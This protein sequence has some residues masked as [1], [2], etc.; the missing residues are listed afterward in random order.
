MIRQEIQSTLNLFKRVHKKQIAPKTPLLSP[1]ME[2]SIKRKN[3]KRMTDLELKRLLKTLIKEIDL[4]Q[5]NREK[6]HAGLLKFKDS[7]NSL[8]IN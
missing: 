6:P 3:L 8:I 4:Y 2:A 1:K 5:N 7:L